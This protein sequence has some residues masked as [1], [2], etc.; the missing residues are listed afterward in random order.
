LRAVVEA[1]VLAGESD[2]QIASRL[3]T[4]PEAIGW[5]EKA[6]FDVRDRLRRPDFIASVIRRADPRASRVDEITAARC[7]TYKMLGYYGGSHVLDRAL[8]MLPLTGRPSSALTVDAW[9]A[10][11]AQQAPA[12][13][14]VTTSAADVDPAK[15][16]GLWRVA[17]E[18]AKQS[19]RQGNG[20]TPLEQQFEELI[21]D[22]PWQLGA[23]VES[24]SELE[25]LARTG[26]VEPRAAEM[27][28]IRS[29]HLPKEFAEHF[30]AWQQDPRNAI[31]HDNARAHR[32]DR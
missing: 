2:Q 15:L 28:E 20:L 18:L 5:Y 30:V 32:S 25:H 14:A 24:R 27:A 10:N 26:P 11:V 17:A 13:A 6:C 22:I 21:K 9:L 4:V 8:A 3:G 12:L 19:G 29:G 23:R 31:N 16:I 1:R 7:R